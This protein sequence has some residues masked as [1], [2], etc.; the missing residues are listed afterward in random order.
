[1]NPIRIDILPFVRQVSSWLSARTRR[2]RRLRERAERPL[3]AV[4]RRRRIGRNWRSFHPDVQDG[5]VPSSISPFL[6]ALLGSR[7]RQTDDKLL[8][9][10]ETA[11]TAGAGYAVRD[12]LDLPAL[13]RYKSPH[14]RLR[15]L[16][17]SIGEGSRGKR[18]ATGPE[19]IFRREIRG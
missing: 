9:T 3:E 10:A 4:H 11:E 5:E 12:G 7:P 2:R 8:A 16:P 6:A 14:R 1:M 15:E 18:G 17:E 19:R 13:K